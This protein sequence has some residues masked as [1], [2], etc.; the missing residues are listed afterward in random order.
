MIQT[1]TWRDIPEWIGYYQASS[2]GR[3]RSIDRI[4]FNSWGMPMYRRG[5]ILKPAK[6][7]AGY[8]TVNLQAGPNNKITIGVHRLVAFAF[9]DNIF[10]LPEVNHI[11]TL[12]DDN[13]VENLEWVTKSENVTHTYYMGNKSVKGSK[14][15]SAKLSDKDVEIIKDLYATGKYS[16]ASIGRHF[17]VKYNCI[18]DII[19]G[20]TWNNTG[21][22]KEYTINKGTREEKLNRIKTAII[23]KIKTPVGVIQLE[24]TGRV[25]G[26]FISAS[27]AAK[28]TGFVPHSIRRNAERGTL[29]RGYLWKTMSV[30]KQ[31][32]LIDIE[33]QSLKV[34]IEQ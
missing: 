15:P 10:N 17:N 21:K 4:I 5:K 7:K 31:L 16:F 20:N 12:R 13:R 34:S 14:N 22:K 6:T 33:L 18:A 3:I 2:L 29:Y 32:K 30:D 19:K 26:E 27:D 23:R 25:V 1:E 24:I 11:N 9:L 8:L 28:K